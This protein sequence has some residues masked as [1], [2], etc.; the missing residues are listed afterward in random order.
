VDA[1]RRGIDLR[2]ER[3]GVGRLEFGQLAPVEDARGDV[4]P[5]RR[6]P[7]ELGD[8]GRERAGLARLLA[9]RMAER[10]E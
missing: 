3:V 1:P 9:A 8:V 10:I 5:T 2:L 7:F 6:E 4:D